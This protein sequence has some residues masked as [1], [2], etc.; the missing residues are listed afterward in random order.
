MQATNKNLQFSTFFT[1]KV[2]SFAKN[3]SK[4]FP[5][6]EQQVYWNC[7]GIYTVKSYCDFLEIETDFSIENSLDVMT[8]AFLNT[9]PLRLKNLGI[10]ECIPF[11][12]GSDT[13]HIPRET[14]ENRI[15]Y[16]AVEINELENEGIVSKFLP[17][18]HPHDMSEE[19]SLQS[20]SSLETF[21]EQIERLEVGQQFLYSQDLLVKEI[22]ENL[23]NLSQTDILIN[24]ERIVRTYDEYQWQEICEDFLINCYVTE[25]VIPEE[26]DTISLQQRKISQTEIEKLS[27]LASKIVSGLNQLWIQQEIKEIKVVRLSKWFED[28]QNI[29]DAGWQTIEVF[30]SMYQ[31]ELN[32]ATSTAL[33]TR[34]SIVQQLLDKRTAIKYINF[35]DENQCP[36]ALIA[37]LEQITEENY[38]ILLQVT[39]LKNKTSCYLPYNL[40]LSILDENGKHFM[41]TKAREKDNLIQLQ[42]RGISQNKFSI[43]VKLNNF[44]FKKNFEI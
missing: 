35:E 20:F 9:A 41:E 2:H 22:A 34:N 19:I 28:I 32:L 17:A 44:E 5:Y 8:Q 33:R 38:N 26:M 6:K 37:T 3:T 31:T 7:L 43:V 1:N 21:L 30:R 25:T 29:F 14:R 40:T 10:V 23:G 24:L 12:S 4:V 18:C 39:P 11:S 16:L 36:I 42:F 15:G 13:I 27:E